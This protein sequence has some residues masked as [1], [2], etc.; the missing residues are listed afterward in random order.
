MQPLI[1]ELEFRCPITSS[2]EL[3]CT[4]PYRSNTGPIIYQ[5]NHQNGCEIGV[6]L[7]KIVGGL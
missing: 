5:K 1:F 6:K 3:V 7:A 4:T 2:Y